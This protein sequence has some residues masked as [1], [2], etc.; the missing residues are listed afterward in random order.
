MAVRLHCILLN[1]ALIFFVA[2]ASC[3][4]EIVGD[5][6]RGRATAF[7]REGRRLFA[8]AAHVLL[9]NGSF[10]LYDDAGRKIPLSG[11]E[12]Y[13]GRDLVVLIPQ[14]NSPAAREPGRTPLPG[15]AAFYRDGRGAVRAVD[16]GTVWI[17]GEA[18][19]AG[20]SGGPV[21]DAAGRPFAI[22]RGMRT[23]SGVVEAVRIDN[24]PVEKREFIEADQFARWLAAYESLRRTGECL[25]A[26]APLQ[27]AALRRAGAVLLREAPER[28]SGW[29]KA[30][31]AAWDREAE[32]LYRAAA[33]LGLSPEGE[34][35]RLRFSYSE[36]GWESLVR[37][38]GPPAFS[39]G[40]A[41]WGIRCCRRKGRTIWAAYC[42]RG[43]VPGEIGLSVDPEED[44]SP[45]DWDRDEW[46]K[47]NISPQFKQ[48][49]P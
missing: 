34:E 31:D 48:K 43:A 42:L 29:G 11:L 26:L 14:E 39:V 10:E 15:G 47:N 36:K 45:R 12:W 27:G 23:D 35:Y 32:K 37:V 33:F 49:K 44:G 46:V 6:T 18:I 28:R 21:S 24:L 2:I 1:A 9:G 22:L 38:Y 8:T 16:S 19:P 20:E 25:D 13:A 30:L 3:G 7:S 17:D 4:Q 5:R 41:E 40:G